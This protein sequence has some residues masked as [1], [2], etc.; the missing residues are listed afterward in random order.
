[1]V[2]NQKNLKIL[3]QPFLMFDKLKNYYKLRF[4]KK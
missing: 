1:M 2:T 3:N 4:Y